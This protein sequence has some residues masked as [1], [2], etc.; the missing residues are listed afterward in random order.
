MGRAVIP[1]TS[2]RPIVV[3]LTPVYN[4]SAGLD[5]YESGVTRTLLSRSDCD[6]RVLFIEDGSSDDSWRKICAI[7]ARDP[8]F[9]G[10]RLSRNY[11]SHIALSAGFANIGE[12][13]AVATLAC[14]LQDPPE[15]VAQFIDRWKAGAD[16]VWGKR[17]SRDEPF[18]RIMTS[19]LFESL[20]RRHAMP[21]RSRFTTGSFLLVDRKVADCFAQFQEHNRV[22][23]ALVAWTGFRE[24]VVEY[25]RQRRRTGRSGWTYGRMVKTMYDTFIGFSQTPIRLMT[26]TGGVVSLLTIPMAA[27]LLYHRIVGHPILGWTST[28]LPMTLFFGLQFLMMG[29]VGE[30]LYRI[31]AE[32]VRRPLYFVSDATT[33]EARV[34]HGGEV[35]R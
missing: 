9:R 22:T 15:V 5:A 27:Y 23:F 32:V 17:V 25:Q 16:I 18:I 24:E 7:A 13:D 31:Y 33:S 14:D 35:V 21:S 19:R 29:I 11:G 10:I 34:R 26:V 20:I 3:L 30:Y 1:E 2:H 6:V 4:E 8:R 28:M 12:A